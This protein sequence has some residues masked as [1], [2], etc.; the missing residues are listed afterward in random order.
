MKTIKK[1][2]AH[3]IAPVFFTLNGYAQ[4]NCL[5]DRIQVM[6][7]SLTKGKQDA[8][9]V[10]RPSNLNLSASKLASQQY[11]IPVVFHVFDDLTNPSYIPSENELVNILEEVNKAF[12][13]ERADTNLIATPFK[14]IY[15]NSNIKFML[16]KKDPSGN[17]TSGIT[18][19]NSPKA[20]WDFVAS[21]SPGYMPTWDPTKYL[22]V[23][24]VNEILNFQSPLTLG[25][26]GYSS[27][28]WSYP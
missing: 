7:D 19:Y 10:T 23:I 28:P 11:I 18:F 13:R 26:G 24:L 25:V 4:F 16:A 3:A 14:N 1:V 20:I 22:N 12:A 21:F 15:V 17:C 8:R 2:L 6:Y 9:K 5:N 27:F